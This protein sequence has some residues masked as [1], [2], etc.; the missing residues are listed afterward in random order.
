MERSVAHDGPVDFAV[1]GLATPTA[2]ELP[3]TDSA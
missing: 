3:G 2:L 1:C